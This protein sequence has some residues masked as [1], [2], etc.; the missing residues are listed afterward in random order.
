MFLKEIKIIEKE[1]RMKRKIIT[2]IAALLFIM[3]VPSALWAFTVPEGVK[4]YSLN[5]TLIETY[6]NDD[7][8]VKTYY[9]YDSINKA[10][11]DMQKYCYEFVMENNIRSKDGAYYQAWANYNWE[12]LATYGMQVYCLQC[13]LI[14]YGH[15]GDIKFPIAV[16][17]VYSLKTQSVVHAILY[18]DTVSHACES[19]YD[20]DL[21]DIQY[22]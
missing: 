3:A 7:G 10:F 19:F 13:N 14:S 16:V 5:S 17:Y 22:H 1:I 6:T 8:S 9:N 11:L 18:S 21:N 12:K 4:D 20:L 2:T 15:S